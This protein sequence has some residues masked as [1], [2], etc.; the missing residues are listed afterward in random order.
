TGLDDVRILNRIA[1]KPLDAYATEKTLGELVRRFDYAFR[2]WEPP[3]FYRPVL[4]RRPVAEND[5]LEVAGLRLRL[6][7]QDHGFSHTLGLRIGPFAYSTDV[8][9][10][11][12]AAFTT[13]AG[14]DTWVVGCY[15]REPAHKT[16]AHLPV[17]L[18]WAAR[19]G[20]RRTILTHMGVDM[21]WAWL[22]ANLPPG[23]EPG[24]D[25]MV[26]DFPG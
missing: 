3:G 18:D 15:Q 23:V 17:A 26:V 2:D 7:D 19:V 16:H 14:V 25:G 20:A 22:K 13:L 4:V 21:D 1:G 12:E 8:V 6:F 5:E 24:F 11:N 9:R 10:L